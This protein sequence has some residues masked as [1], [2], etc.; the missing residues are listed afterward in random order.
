ME[1]QQIHIEQEKEVDV[2]TANPAKVVLFNDNVHTFDEV[3]AQIVKAL[4]CDSAKAESIAWEAHSRGK[5]LVFS[6]E[7]EECLKVNSVLEEIALH[8][9]I[10][11]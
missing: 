4:R 9:H 2:L 1:Q 3:I 5:A 10:E 11:M 7:V 6:G 8:T